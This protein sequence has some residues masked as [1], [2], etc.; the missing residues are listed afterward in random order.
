MINILPIDIY[1]NI[2]SFLMSKDNIFLL[3]TCKYTIKFL[4]K[5]LDYRITKN[6][7]HTEVVFPLLPNK[8]NETQKNIYKKEFFLNIPK[9]LNTI[10]KILFWFHIHNQLIKYYNISFLWNNK[11]LI[12][13]NKK[14]TKYEIYVELKKKLNFYINHQNASINLSSKIVEND[15]ISTSKKYWYHQF[16]YSEF[17]N[18]CYEI[19]IEI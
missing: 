3:T 2:N 15:D 18:I 6:L 19:F 16:D 8:F 17:I 12:T 13:S 9:S 7:L 10:H 1:L 5:T 4:Y 14:L 11:I